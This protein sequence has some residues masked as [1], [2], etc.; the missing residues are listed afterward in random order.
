M[1]STHNVFGDQQLELDVTA[2]TI[3]MDAL[4]LC[5]AVHTASSEETP[6]EVLMNEGGR[7][8]VAFD[9][10][11]GSSIVACNWA[12]G[13]IV[14]IWEAKR[15]VGVCGREMVGA[16]VTVYGPRTTMFVAVGDRWGKSGRR[17]VE[18]TLGED[19]WS[20]SLVPGDVK[21]GKLFAPANLRATQDH[22]GYQRLIAWYMK[23]RYTLRYT[24]GMVPDVTQILTK[25]YGVFTSPAS[26][27]APPKLRLLYEVL[28]MAYVIEACGGRSSDGGG[29][30]L[31]LA[32]DKCDQRSTI[33]VGSHDEVV[34]FEAH[35]SI[36]Y[37]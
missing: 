18:F 12:V 24:G 37:E 19:G 4:R 9:P 11:D 8:S 20:V 23:E 36:E 14:G 10:L 34:R 6:V 13:T 17:V 27:K 21:E 1:T 16:V 26:N 5:G 2:D 3:L 35:C 29:S 32:V 22:A 25:G 31:R 15:L 30:V 28:P 7:L 33:C